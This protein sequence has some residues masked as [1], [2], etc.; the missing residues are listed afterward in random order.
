MSENVIRTGRDLAYQG[1]V[2]K[3][4]K[5]H[6]KFSNG[7][8]EEWDFI[9]LHQGFALPVSDFLQQKLRFFHRKMQPLSEL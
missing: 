5:D 8:T 2:L 3:V 1:T 4:Y 6:M 9:H 7:N